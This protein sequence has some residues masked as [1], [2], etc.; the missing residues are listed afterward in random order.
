MALTLRIVAHQSLLRGGDGSAS[1]ISCPQ[2]KDVDS[3][4]CKSLLIISFSQTYGYRCTRDNKMERVVPQ[5]DKMNGARYLTMFLEQV[6]VV[7]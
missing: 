7:S 6:M 2:F 3:A 1:M 5:P 4:L